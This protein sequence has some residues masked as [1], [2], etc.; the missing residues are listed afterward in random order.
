MDPDFG[1][2]RRKQPQ[3]SPFPQK[4]TW[5]PDAEPINTPRQPTMK[6]LFPERNHTQPAMTTNHYFAMGNPDLRNTHAY[7]G[8]G[9]LA[10]SQIERSV[11]SKIHDSI[12]DFGPRSSRNMGV[13][14]SRDPI[15]PGYAGYIPGKSFDSYLPSHN[16]H[17]YHKDLQ[18]QGSEGK[19]QADQPQDVHDAFVSTFKSDETNGTVRGA[20]RRY[21]QTKQSNPFAGRCYPNVADPFAH[22]EYRSKDPMH[23][24]GSGG[25]DLLNP[26][27]SRL[28]LLQN[29]GGFSANDVL[30]LRQQQQQQQ[31]LPP[32]QRENVVKFRVPSR[33]SGV[34]LVQANEDSAAQPDNAERQVWTTLPHSAPFW[35]V[36]S[37][38]NGYYARS[39]GQFSKNS[40]SESSKFTFLC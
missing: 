40:S 21:I 4:P 18:R 1:F 15:S 3:P 7:N 35:S 39:P 27:N 31:Q 5:G 9:A 38:L 34:R 14:N 2:Y 29:E 28:R 10:Q 16:D 33:S 36:E 37:G 13:A 26:N 19:R 11:P 20:G 22:G 30:Q 6:K 24:M 32:R 12:N 25:A 17:Q 23:Y 8:V